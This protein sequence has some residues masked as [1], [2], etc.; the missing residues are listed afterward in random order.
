[1]IW[2]IA[3]KNIPQNLKDLSKIV[4]KEKAQDNKNT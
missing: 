4:D 3:K 1:M 2:E